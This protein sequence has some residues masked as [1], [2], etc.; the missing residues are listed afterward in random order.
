MFS[1][2]ATQMTY[3]NFYFLRKWIPTPYFQ[4]GFT[5]LSSQ[6][7]FATLNGVNMSYINLVLGLHPCN[8]LAT[9]TSSVYGVQIRTREVIY[10]D[11]PLIISLALLQCYF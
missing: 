4:L 7:F 8:I 10:F 11:C 6:C 9:S 3:V 2:S 1:S 5:P